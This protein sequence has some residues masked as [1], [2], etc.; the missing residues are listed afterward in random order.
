MN[1]P[2]TIID[3]ETPIIDEETQEKRIQRLE[4]IFELLD[5][6]DSGGIDAEELRI[7][8]KTLSSS[9]DLPTIEESLAQ[10]QK[11]DINQNNEIE[12]VATFD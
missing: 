8:G 4:E 12:Y 1:G 5:Q 3:E 6:D 9:V 10:L 7:L 11:A 2:C